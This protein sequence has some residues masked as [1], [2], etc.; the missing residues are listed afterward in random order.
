M[1]AAIQDAPSWR[2][3][4]D[5]INFWSRLPR[6]ILL[7]QQ[8]HQQ[9]SEQIRTMPPAGRRL[10]ITAWERQNDQLSK[11]LESVRN[12]GM[13]L[14]TAT[15]VISGVITLL[16]PIIAAAHGELKPTSLLPAVLLFVAVVAF[17]VTTYCAV[18]T[19]VLGI[20]SQ[21]VDVWAQSELHPGDGNSALAY[22]LVYA[23][24]LY[25]TYSDN[26]SRFANP[27]GYLRQAQAYFRTLVQALA[28]LLLASVVAVAAGVLVPDGGA[29]GSHLSKLRRVRGH[30]FRSQR[31]GGEREQAAALP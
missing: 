30:A 24:T 10:L 8:Q 4:Y 14:L 1:T 21:E 17:L 20:R 2:R 9:I 31:R 29:S 6:A 27:V 19:V 23:F 28:V 5:W 12:R 3:A 22:E 15:G 26:V 16:I 11:D 25:I 7:T 18:A 13:A